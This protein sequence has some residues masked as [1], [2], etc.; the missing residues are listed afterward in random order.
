[1]GALALRP[2]HSSLLHTH[3]E[4]MF[5]LADFCGESKVVS[6]SQVLT[7]LGVFKVTYYAELPGQ[8]NCCSL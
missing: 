4:N 1:M 2:T 6:S 5:V 8:L 3:D 7:A